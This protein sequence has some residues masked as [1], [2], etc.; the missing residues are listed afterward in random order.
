[1]ATSESDSQ[2]EYVDRKRLQDFEHWSSGARFQKTVH[3]GIYVCDD[4]HRERWM[5]YL[6]QGLYEPGGVYSVWKANAHWKIKPD[7]GHGEI[8]VVS[9]Q[10]RIG[11]GPM[12][13]LGSINKIT[14]KDIISPPMC[15]VVVEKT[16]RTRQH[17]PTDGDQ[18]E[19]ASEGQT[20]RPENHKVNQPVKAKQ[21]EG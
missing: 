17:K 13:Q 8:I 14:D 19:S 12:L 4:P 2:T 3:Q 15:C 9:G 6:C 16:K 7:G 21:T 11:S 5:G 10:P 18:N 20:N 1:M